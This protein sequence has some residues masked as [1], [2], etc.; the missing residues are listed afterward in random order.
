MND[1]LSA[2]V[3]EWFKKANSKYI[4]EM[5][6]LTPYAVEIRYPDDF[7]M[8]SED[9]AL[10]AYKIASEIKNFILQKIGENS[11]IE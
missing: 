5:E 6:K 7:Y 8:Q 11:A 1:E 10:E 3:Q 2:Y 9:E 4:T